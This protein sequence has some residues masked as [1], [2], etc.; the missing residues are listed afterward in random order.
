MVQFV[1]YIPFAKQA[2]I[3]CTLTIEYSHLKNQTRNPIHSILIP[4]T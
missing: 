4:R 2:K 1:F 3:T